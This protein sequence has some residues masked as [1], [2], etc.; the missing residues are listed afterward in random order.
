MHDQDGKAG[1]TGED[2]DRAPA[3]VIDQE[4]A[5]AGR[6]EATHGEGHGEIGDGFHH[7]LGAVDV[8]GD[9]ARQRDAAGGTGGLDDPA[10]QQADERGGEPR[11]DA[12]D[13]E[14]RETHQQHRAAPVAVAQRAI[15]QR[16]ERQGKHD[17]G[18]G[19]LGQRIGEAELRLDHGDDREEEVERHRRQEREP[20]EQEI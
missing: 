18:E 15:G 4:P 14:Q 16:R 13:Q 11:E 2:E 9:G 20:A 3:G 8:A 1:E 17:D 19:E 7:A 12:A 5:D 6:R 10:D